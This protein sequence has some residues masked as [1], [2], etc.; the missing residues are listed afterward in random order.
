[1]RPFAVVGTLSRSARGVRRSRKTRGPAPTTPPLRSPRGPR[2]G[3]VR[4]CAGASG[5]SFS[6]RTRKFTTPVFDAGVHR[7]TVPGG[8][9]LGRHRRAR[10]HLRR[11]APSGQTVT[12]QHLDDSAPQS[13]FPTNPVGQSGRAFRCLTSSVARNILHRPRTRA[14]AMPPVHWPAH[15]STWV[16]RR[17]IVRLFLGYPPKH[18]L[19]QRELHDPK[20][21]HP[22]IVVAKKLLRDPLE[23]RI[24]RERACGR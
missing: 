12:V 19:H 18:S 3:P 2:R 21:L 13:S 4:R 23:I 22:L 10:E 17:G 15:E 20:A 7:F 8:R 1:M 9:S 16:L 6:A 24:H 14:G 5:F 11:S